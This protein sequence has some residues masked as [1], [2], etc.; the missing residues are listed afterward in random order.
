MDFLKNYLT[1]LPIVIIAFIAL[2]GLVILKV[3]RSYST[4]V[5]RESILK[6][7][8]EGPLAYFKG[9]KPEEK[10]V[11]Q[12]ATQFQKLKFWIREHLL[13]IGVAKDKSEIS[14]SFNEA[15]KNLKE[16][17]GGKDYLYKLPLYLLVGPSGSGKSSI[18]QSLTINLPLG[19]PLAQE[20][21]HPTCKWWIFDH[22]IVLDVIGN[23]FLHKSG[24]SSEKR[25]WTKLLH[26]LSIYRASR[27]VDGVILTIPADELIGSHKLAISEVAARGAVI[28][29]NLLQVQKTLGMKVPVYV[30]VTKSDK[31]PGFVGFSQELPPRLLDEMMGW[32]SPYG[33]ETSYTSNWVSDAFDYIKKT[34]HKIRSEIFTEGDVSLNVDSVFAYKV[35]F[36]NIQENLSG[37]L[38]QI[39][40]NSSYLES[41]FL[42][43]VYLAGDTEIHSAMAQ[44]MKATGTLGGN[45]AMPFAAIDKHNISFIKDLFSKKIFPEFSLAAPIRSLLSSTSKMLTLNKILAVILF[46]VWGFGLYLDNAQ[47]Q[48]NQESINA[49]MM[50]VDQTLHTV[51]SENFDLSQ[52]HNASYLNEQAYK[53]LSNFSDLS[54]T[55]SFSLFIPNS[56]FS[57]YDNK[58][59]R[60]L[61]VIWNEII[62]KS[63]YTGLIQKA[64]SLLVSLVGPENN[65]SNVAY[66][67]PIDMPN[68]QRLYTFINEAVILE[69]HILKFNDISKTREV[70]DV[71]TIIRYLFHKDLPEQFYQNTKFYTLALGKTVHKNIN[72]D[73]YRDSAQ[74][75]LQLWYTEFLDE[76]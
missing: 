73:E 30:V 52:P 74:R 76:S 18:M 1:Y 14:H 71:G 61:A 4:T 24:D 55:S 65:L 56:W 57:N 45:I 68:F 41:F 33:L 72:L 8:M 28:A 37:Y 16:H 31:I 46:L 7:A 43:G 34:L 13:R 51:S 3:V 10:D 69:R 25:L 5:A 64:R 49:L 17:F 11:E 22:G 60:S 40:K 47:L 9:K 53:V 19:R 26:L 6:R 29:N 21:L 44:S 48:K 27:P 23:C 38:N 35:Q 15:V 62:L 50:E 54:A 20:E 75:K 59:H 2:A 42:R 67:N 70:K 58:I 36:E 39:F 32:S 63:M 12:P 66:L